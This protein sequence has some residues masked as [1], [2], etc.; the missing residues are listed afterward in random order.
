M[1]V[2]NVELGHDIVGMRKRA[3]ISMEHL[4]TGNIRFR[5]L[6][7]FNLNRFK[8]AKRRKFKTKVID[9]ILDQVIFAGCRFLKEAKDS[10]PCN[11]METNRS[12]AWEVL[13]IRDS[14][15][16]IA[17]ALRDKRQSYDLAEVLARLKART[18]VQGTDSDM[19]SH[20]HY[21][22]ANALILTVKLSMQETDIHINRVLCNTIESVGLEINPK[23]TPAAYNTKVQSRQFYPTERIPMSSMRPW[24]NLYSSQ[25]RN[26]PS[27]VSYQGWQSWPWR[28]RLEPPQPYVG[29]TNLHNFKEGIASNQAMKYSSTCPC[30]EHKNRCVVRCPH[31]VEVGFRKPWHYSTYTPLRLSHEVRMI[32]K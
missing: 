25:V 19:A 14:R 21:I 31:F 30:T 8:E 24:S 17:H 1:Q 15:L 13:D 22:A 2:R 23:N 10:N 5:F 28:M 18:G 32:K 12:D 27:K 9:S 20:S 16:K 26:L 3:L 4:S 6:I 29:P 7:S 11:S